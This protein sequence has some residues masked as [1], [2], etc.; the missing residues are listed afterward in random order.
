MSE[1]V[2][3]EKCDVC[4][5]SQDCGASRNHQVSNPVAI[6]CANTKSWCVKL[7]KSAINRHLIEAQGTQTYRHLEI[8]SWHGK[9]LFN[10]SSC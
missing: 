10:P 8:D 3:Y 6:R 9:I 2:K 5:L 4:L 1:N 7:C